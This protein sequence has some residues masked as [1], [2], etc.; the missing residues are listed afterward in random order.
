MTLRISGDIVLK[1]YN[2][3]AAIAGV[4]PTLD[5]RFA[6][7][8]R[9][10]DA[11]SLTDKLTVTRAATAAVN[12]PTGYLELANANV[13]RFDHDPTTGESL[14]LLVEESRTNAVLY[15]QDFD[16]AYW[17]KRNSVTVT[18]NAIAAPDG[19]ATADELIHPGGTTFVRIE[20]VPG[21]SVVSGTQYT[22]SIFAKYKPS[23]EAT[24]LAIQFQRAFGV[25]YVNLS[26]KAVLSGSDASVHSLANGWMRISWTFSA[27]STGISQLY[28]YPTNTTSIAPS[29]SIAANSG[30][31]IWGA[32]LEAGSYAT[33]YIPTTSATVPRTESASIDGAG[34]I[35][36]TYTMVEKPA[37]CVVVNGTNIDLQTGYT[38]ERVMVFPV[39]LS[40]S[41]IAA[42]RNAM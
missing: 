16:N 4:A 26:T 33:S 40:D 32:Q 25:I 14:G 41:Q 18:A 19:T 9:E 6:L 17:F 29:P 39:A 31:Y 1:N 24:V 23:S 15:S 5:Y 12:G 3:P 28:L 7:D 35:T 42:I 36:G 10:L 20:T 38:A 2:T 21:A 34:V 27:T 37:G 11:V 22:A 30:L 8:R 13:A